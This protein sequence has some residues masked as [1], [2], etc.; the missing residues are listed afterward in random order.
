MIGIGPVQFHFLAVVGY[1]EW[2]RP[3]G[4]LP[5]V[6][7]PGN[8]VPVFIVAF[9]KT[10]QVVID[11]S[12]CTS[13]VLGSIVCIAGFFDFWGV[14]RIRYP[15]FFGN[16]DCPVDA[17]LQLG[18]VCFFPATKGFGYDVQ[19]VVIDKLLNFPGFGV[20]DPIKAEVK[21]RLIKLEKLV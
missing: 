7:A 2:C 11:L 12:L 4:R 6:I 21:V 20:H 10:I 16:L 9:K 17:S 3:A 8:E 14:F 5:G 19:Q 15:V 18:V 13:G 1:G